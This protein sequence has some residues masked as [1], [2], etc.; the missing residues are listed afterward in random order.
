MQWQRLLKQRRGLLLLKRLQGVHNLW[1][2]LPP[3]T[4]LQGLSN[5]WKL[6]NMKPLALQKNSS[7]KTCQLIPWRPLRQYWRKQQS[8]MT[9]LSSVFGQEEQQPQQP[10]PSGWLLAQICSLLGQ[11]QQQQQQQPQSCSPLAKLLGQQQMHPLQQQPSGSSLPQILLGQQQQQHVPTSDVNGLAHVFAL[12][13]QHP[14]AAV[15]G[16]SNFLSPVSGWHGQQ[17]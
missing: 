11:Q 12:L 6:Y 1:K 5:L 3:L 17:Q 14:P 15:S 10:P 9:Q 4:T 7:K 2:R 16:S 13:K 8:P